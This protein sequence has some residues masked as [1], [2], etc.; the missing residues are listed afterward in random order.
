MQSLIY[1]PEQYV[2]PGNIIFR[3]RGTHWFP[4]D[5][6]AM[7]RDHTIYATQP[8]YVKYYRDPLK[9][10][11]R[12]Y[13]G[14][15][16]ERNQVLPQ[17]PHAVRRRRLGMLAYQMPSTVTS[18]VGDLVTGESLGMS[19]NAGMGAGQPSTIREAPVEA[20]GK[21][22][23]KDKRTQEVVKVTPT[24]RPGYQYRMANWEIGRAAERAKI[25]VDPFKP[26]DRFKAWRKTAVRKAKNAER[27]GMRRR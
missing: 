24:L 9:H 18:T 7:G 8:G 12:A 20:R 23:V 22:V 27:R 3:Q 15:V 21:V 13:I 5:N 2:I 14:V 4:G 19:G 11:D 25:Q 26:G 10:P 1:A 6:C 17:P 16:F